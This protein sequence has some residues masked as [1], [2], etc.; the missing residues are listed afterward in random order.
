MTTRDNIIYDIRDLCIDSIHT[1]MTAHSHVY[2]QLLKFIVKLHSEH[3]SS[4]SRCKRH[5]RTYHI[6]CYRNCGFV[7]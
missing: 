4:F 1:L 2:G 5:L 7:L 6:R 3:S